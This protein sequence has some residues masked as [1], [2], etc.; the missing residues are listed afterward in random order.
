MLKLGD[1]GGLLKQ[2]QQLQEQMA[3]IQDELSNVIVDGMSG[4]GMVTVKANA[5]REVL[6]IKIEPEVVDSDDIE[7]LEDLVV[8]AVNNAL[9]KAQEAAK[10]RVSEASEGLMDKLPPGIKLPWM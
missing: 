7:M 9:E 5:K 4:G 1:L 3:K 2:A 8:A 10:D 6:E